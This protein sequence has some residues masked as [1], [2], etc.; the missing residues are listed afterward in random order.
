VIGETACSGELNQDPDE[1][2]I[3]ELDRAAVEVDKLMPELIEFL[4]GRGQVDASK[5]NS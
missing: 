5:N 4:V 3:N 2:L 1:L